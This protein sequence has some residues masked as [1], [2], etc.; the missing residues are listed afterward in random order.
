MAPADVHRAEVDEAANL[1]R[2]F[3]GAEVEGCPNLAIGFVEPL[4][5]ELEGRPGA[6]VPLPGELGELGELTETSSRPSGLRAG[7]A[8]S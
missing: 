2:Q 4:E 8:R 5:E 1:R 3:V 6:V 7:S